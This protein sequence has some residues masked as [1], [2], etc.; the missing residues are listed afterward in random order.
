M[1][2]R[3]S[4]RPFTETI[5][6]LDG[7]AAKMGLSPSQALRPDRQIATSNRVKP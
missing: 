1:A 6:S 5:P 4:Q 3:R 2:G 7:A